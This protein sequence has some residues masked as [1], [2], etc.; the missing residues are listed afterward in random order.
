MKHHYALTLRAARRRSGLTQEDCAHFLGIT[1]PRMSKI[2]SGV[3][4]PTLK[5]ACALCILFD[6]PLTELYSDTALGVARQFKDRLPTV[7]D[8]PLLWRVKQ[9]RLDTLA[10]LRFRLEARNK[11]TP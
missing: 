10:S 5:E 11:R 3:Y 2:E 8:A 1:Q 9:R 4:E 6:M 7:P